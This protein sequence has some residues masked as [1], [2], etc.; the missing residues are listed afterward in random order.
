MI[1]SFEF[2]PALLPLL[3][4]L[5]VTGCDEGT[6]SSLKDVLGGNG[7]VGL[8]PAVEVARVT[9]SSSGGDVIVNRPGTAVDG[10]RITVPAGAYGGSTEFVV[11]TAEVRSHTLGPYFNPD[12]P[13]IM[14]SEGGGYAA[15]VLNMRIPMRS[16][17]GRF[18]A[19]FYYDSK[20]GKLEGI[21]TLRLGDGYIDVGVRHFS[22]IVVT[23][24]QKELLI[25]GG[26]YDTYFH[27][28]ENGWSFVNDGTYPTYKGN[29]AGMSL[30]AAYFY[31]DFRNN[32]N[33]RRFF[34]NE[35]LWWQTPAFWEDDVTALK[36]VSSVQRRFISTGRWSDNGNIST[37]LT[38]DPQLRYFNLVYAMLL[39]RK[40]QV[41]YLEAS[42]TTPRQAHA[43]LAH[44]YTATRT[45]GSLKIYDP[46]YPGNTGVITFDL[47]ADRFL[48]YQS[49]SNATA[50][51]LG[52]VYEYDSIA[53][54][55]YSTAVDAGEMDE[56][57]RQVKDRTIGSGLYPAYEL[58]AV[59]KNN[60]AVPK[61]RLQDAAAGKENHIPDKA[62]DF[63]IVSGDPSLTLKMI[64]YQ[65]Y[66]DLGIAGTD[67]IE[68]I[69]LK[70]PKTTI[71]I[72]VS[73]IPPGATS[74]QWIG[75]HWMN[76]VKQTLWIDPPE[77]TGGV[78]Q[79]ITFTARSEGSAPATARY[80]WNFGDGTPVVIVLN[81]STVDHSFAT[82]GQYAVKCTVV[83]TVTK[84]IFGEARSSATIGML[85]KL[86]ITM[87]GMEAG[88][89]H[90]TIK[91]S[92]GSDLQSFGFTNMTQST[93]PL[94]WS[95]LSFS[96]THRYSL[97]G[98]NFTVTFAGRISADWKK[99][100][101]VTCTASGVLGDSWEH[102][103]TLDLR[104]IPLI[105]QDPGN[106]YNAE[107]RGETAHAAVASA[108]Y[109]TRTKNSQDVWETTQLQ[110]ID[111]SSQK[112]RLT[113]LLTK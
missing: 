91:L 86:V 12:S 52:H 69:E 41:V 36:F 42:A 59:P 7:A 71:G 94:V 63:E 2:M 26:G 65:E 104:D 90:S 8:G 98:S 43:I 28:T 11:S 27:P 75:F 92:D 57:W 96:A 49:G 5:C 93:T 48:P 55:P 46:N 24:V 85:G 111:W 73:G 103:Q 30:G 64:S 4:V 109:T 22:W 107:L 105:E 13:M 74:Q 23:D 101:Y 14:V 56:L 81:D 108:A 18:P 25:D 51:A 50:V 67:P 68:T 53:Y 39:T 78:N 17:P 44:A 61:I 79:P 20:T 6:P 76:F 95:G 62:F 100:D 38:A 45:G 97:A 29:C 84:E 58:Y 40:P 72:L 89:A 32:M 110:S 9:V 31:E 37:I 3:L 102:L 83:N 77:A 15:K 34:D 60:S 113:V 16:A 1:R 80:E 10:L 70:D 82:S 19:A 66:K 54:L 99:I 35:G 112:T 106:L 47:V 87:Y 21:T 33:L 88:D